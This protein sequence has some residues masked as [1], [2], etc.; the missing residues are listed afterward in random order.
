MHAGAQGLCPVACSAR[1]WARER[2]LETSCAVSWGSGGAACRC[3]FLYYS[4]WGGPAITARG[5]AL[6]QL[7]ASSSKASASGDHTS[8]EFWRQFSCVPGNL[9]LLPVKAQ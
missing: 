8:A 5:T 1:L 3:G 7:K 6:V 4:G 9:L 2:T